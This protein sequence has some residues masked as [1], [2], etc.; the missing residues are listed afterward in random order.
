MTSST[1]GR[2]NTTRYTYDSDGNMTSVTNAL[3]ETISYT[4]DANGNWHR[5]DGCAGQYDPVCL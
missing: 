5:H 4:Y 1:D 2:G 3:N